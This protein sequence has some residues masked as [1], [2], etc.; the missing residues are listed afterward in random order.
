MR[1]LAE[2]VEELTSRKNYVEAY[3]DA[4]HMREEAM[5]LFN[6]GQLSLADRARCEEFY[7]RG[8]QAILAITRKLDYVPDDLGH[9]E[10][11]NWPIPTS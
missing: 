8:C 6:M 4:V 10:Q 3:H 7:W 9:L 1:R 11:A 5:L 2:L